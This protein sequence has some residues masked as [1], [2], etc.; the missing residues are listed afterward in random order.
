MKV[1]ETELSH[2]GSDCEWC[3]RYIRT[4]ASASLCQAAC[5][6]F[7]RSSRAAEKSSVSNIL[8]LTGAWQRELGNERQPRSVGNSAR[9]LLKAAASFGETYSFPPVVSKSCNSV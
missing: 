1:D 3:W 2:S 9:L 4:W 8:S 6:N 7:N 5:T